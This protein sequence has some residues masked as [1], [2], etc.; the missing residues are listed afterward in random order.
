MNFNDVEKIVEE[1]KI[2]Y[3][4]VYFKIDYIQEDDN[5]AVNLSDAKV[6]HSDEFN[7]F[8]GKKLVD[9]FQNGEDFN[10]FFCYDSQLEEEI[11]IKKIDFISNL[12]VPEIN[13]YIFFNVKYNNT[14]N[15]KSSLNENLV[16]INSI[17]QN[18][19]AA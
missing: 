1:L 19:L 18:S 6:A 2:L 15:I 10:V 14:K 5:Y 4:N 9:A 16:S 8:I 17:N 7:I 12:I 11:T 3:P 13:N